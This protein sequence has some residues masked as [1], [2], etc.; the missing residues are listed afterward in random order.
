V[1]LVQFTA[2]DAWLMEQLETDPRAM[3]EL[4]GPVPPEEIPAI[5]ERRLRYITEEGAWLYCLVP[6]PGQPPVGTVGLWHGDWQGEPVS[7]MGWMVLPE[8]QGRGYASAGLAMLIDRAHAD[9][10]WGALH[11]FPGVTN[12][13][14]NALCRKAGMELVGEGDGGYRGNDFRVN[15]WVLR[16]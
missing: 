13:P 1:E 9:G 7:E 5:V 12:G 2:A 10:S 8:H 6:E 4:G 3:A 15:H 14:S 11:A 16:G